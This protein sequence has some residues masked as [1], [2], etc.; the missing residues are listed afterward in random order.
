[1]SMK[2]GVSLPQGWNMELV[3]IKD[4][5]EAYEAMTRV[6]QIIKQAMSASVRPVRSAIG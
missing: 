2:F 6:A 3:G 5:V 1:M 4:P